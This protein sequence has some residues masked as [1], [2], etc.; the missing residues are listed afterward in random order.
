MIQF[1][2]LACESVLTAKQVFLHQGSGETTLCWELTKAACRVCRDLGIHSA[3]LNGTETSEE[4][5]FCFFWCYILDKTFTCRFGSSS[6]QILLGDL[7][8][9]SLMNNHTISELLAIYLEIAKIQE[10][11]IPYLGNN[12]SFPAI[13]DSF[14]S[15]IIS[16]M[17]RLHERIT[18]V[19]KSNGITSSA[20]LLIIGQIE[21]PSPRWKGMDIQKEMSALRY[22]YY[23][24]KTDIYYIQMSTGRSSTALEGCLQSAR[25][26]LTGIVSMYLSQE[27]DKDIQRTVSFLHWCVV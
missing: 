6:F 9:R 25:Q 12:S 7:D 19:G 15:R 10:M 27:S 8:Y 5:Y 22:A 24:V 17:D 11:I 26:Q 13:G 16:R 21:L 4:A 23:T 2:S 20:C 3:L 18:R 1:V 14:F